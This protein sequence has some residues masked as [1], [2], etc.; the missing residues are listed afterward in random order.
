MFEWT[1]GQMTFCHLIPRIRPFQNA[2]STI[3]GSSKATFQLLTN[4]FSR[5]TSNFFN[6]SKCKEKIEILALAGH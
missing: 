5:I 2:S 1:D 3:N 6:S 4:N